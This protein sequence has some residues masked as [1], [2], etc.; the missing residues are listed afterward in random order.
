VVDAV[1]LTARTPAHATG[2]ADVAITTSKG[3]TTSA[4]AFR[5][6]ASKQRAVRH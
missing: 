2:A 3:S 6:L 5:F 4:G 1:T